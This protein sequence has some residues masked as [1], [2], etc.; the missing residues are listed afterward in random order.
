M[1]RSTSGCATT[2]L[3][4]W[5]AR[6]A[7]N[8]SA[9]AFAVS[10]CAVHTAFSSKFGN[11]CRAGTWAL[12]PQ[13]LPS[14]VTKPVS[15][16]DARDFSVRHGRVSQYRGV[17]SNGESRQR[18]HAP[19]SALRARLPLR[20]QHCFGWAPG[21]AVPFPTDPLADFATLQARVRFAAGQLLIL[22]ALN[23]GSRNHD[24]SARPDPFVGR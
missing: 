13:P 8:F 22:Q 9:E 18:P 19:I 4:S 6:S 10:A 15:P 7:P 20:N 11:A 5:K 17:R 16:D 1:T 24:R 12:A 3:M 14:G 23:I 21:P 2:W